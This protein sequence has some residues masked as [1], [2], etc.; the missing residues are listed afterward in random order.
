MQGGRIGAGRSPSYSCS[1]GW[2][3]TNS[4]SQ[5]RP[6]AP[7]RLVDGWVG[8][9]CGEDVNSPFC[10]PLLIADQVFCWPEW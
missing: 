9:R 4:Y 6:P 7:L 10:S 8:E 3:N 5:L 1:A 2:S